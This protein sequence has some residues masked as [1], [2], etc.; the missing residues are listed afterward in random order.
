M[1]SPDSL[2]KNR[3]VLYLGVSDTPAWIVSKANQYARDHGLAQFVIYQGLWSVRIR[4]FERE[5]IP[6][7]VNERLAIAPWGAIGGGKFKSQKEI[8]ERE[9]KGDKLRNMDGGSELNETETKVSAALEKVAD[10]H[11][12][13]A[14]AY[15]LARAPYVFPI[16]GG[17][18][19][20]HL[21]DNIKAL[22][23]ADRVF[24]VSGSV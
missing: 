8:K 15:C 4:N 21:Q 2:V 22:G 11:S 16:V 6:M 9:Q 10:E 5:I 7:C 17:R 3:S 12:S 18:K 23:G 20:E 13:V 14:L 19:V 1:H 24:G